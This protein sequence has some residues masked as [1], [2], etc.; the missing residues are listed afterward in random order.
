L[1]PIKLPN[2]RLLW[3]DDAIEQL[4]AGSAVQ[5]ADPLADLHNLDQPN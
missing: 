5:K 2:G 3:P 4:T 1:R